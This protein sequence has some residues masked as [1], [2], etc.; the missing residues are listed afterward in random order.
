[1]PE[2]LFRVLEP[3]MPIIGETF[4]H[5]LIPEQLFRVLQPVM[6]I[7]GEEHFHMF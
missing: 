3:V 5:M 6:P 1:M 7:I 4:P 2:Q